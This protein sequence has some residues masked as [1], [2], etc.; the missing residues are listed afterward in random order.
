M[1]RSPRWM[2]VVLLM[3]AGVTAVS[4]S[5]TSISGVVRDSAGVPQMG[6]L[7]EIYAPSVESRKAATDAHGRYLFSDLV[8]AVYTVKVSA[9]AFLPT[10]RENVAVRASARVVVNLTLST[11]FEA[12]QMMP[13]RRVPS[14]NDD[15]WQWTLRSVANRPIFRLDDSGSPVMVSQADGSSDQA[16]KASIAF[17][18]GSEADGFGRSTDMGTAFTV[19]HSV[20]STGTLTFKGNVGYGD[21]DPDGVLRLSYSHRLANG[22]QPEVAVTFRR[23]ASPSD[24]MPD[25]TLQA[26]A[27]S[28]ANTTS[29]GDRVEL[30]YGGEFQSVQFMGRVTAYRPFGSLDVHLSP[31]TIV[32]Y[33]YATSEPSTRLEKG[34]DTAPAD[35]TESGPH[36]SQD[37]FTPLLEK[38]RHQEISLSRRQG[39]NA[40]QVALFADSI[41]NAALTG[42]GEIGMDSGDFLPDVYSD[43][44][45]YNGGDLVTNGLRLVVQR[46]L[47]DD[48]TATLAYSYGGVLEAGGWNLPWG[49]VQDSMRVGRRH[50][51]TAKFAG[52]VPHCKT[53]VI[54]SYK[55]TND[56]GLT[57]VDLFNASASQADPYFNLFVRQ[58]VPMLAGLPG[59][60]EALV[61]LRNLLEQGYMPVIAP[62]GHTLYLV[63][64]ARSVRG[65]LLFTF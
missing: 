55:W 57:P 48:L 39:R 6:A 17:L 11:L 10:L 53:R 19:E 60:M 33:L 5:N 12:L 47:R 16:L 21:A 27:V 62:D 31:N 30:R 15:D 64:S 13:Q 25:A 4:A 59:H 61:D 8:P 50:A 3:A 49:Q 51:V 58:P 52:T 35:L 38:A 14:D 18:A 9:P 7:V 44:F 40:F 37:G 20:F 32:E 36:M 29:V 63:Q 34:F 24:A 56:G 65:G 42:V 54:A 46:K 28:V 23:F 22:A 41:H 45:T 43:T 2:L 1:A 26:L